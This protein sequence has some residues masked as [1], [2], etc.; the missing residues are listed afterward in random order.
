MS[1][2][3]LSLHKIVRMQL[4]NKFHKVDSSTGKYKEL[5]R[6]D[7]GFKFLQDKKKLT[8][9]V[10]INYFLDEKTLQFNF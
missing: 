7:S 3:I 9:V 1:M 10:V 8:L 6:K 2:L 4:I 5:K